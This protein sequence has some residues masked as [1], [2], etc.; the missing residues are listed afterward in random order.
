M[1]IAC[2]DSRV[3][4]ATVFGAVPGQLFM[5]RS[6]AGLVPPYAPGHEPCTAPAPR[7]NMA[8]AC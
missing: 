1:V 8:C 7:W 4:P 3:D 6:V 2:S 5:V